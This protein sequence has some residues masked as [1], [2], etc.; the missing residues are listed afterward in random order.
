M[1]NQLPYSV[2]V[3]YTKVTGSRPP[4]GDQAKLSELST[5]VTLRIKK[6]N[7]HLEEYKDAP[8]CLMDELK[9]HK[10]N[11][12]AASL[13]LSNM[14]QGLED[15]HEQ[16]RSSLKRTVLDSSRR[17]A[18]HLEY[19]GDGKCQNGRCVL[20]DHLYRELGS[21]GVAPTPVNTGSGNQPGWT[22]P[23]LK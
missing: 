23:M 9:S 21:V 19:N 7:T 12:V 2:N 6:V 5:A 18:K 1:A 15:Y 8:S 3:V 22:F 13:H 17:S 11:L 16:A 14:T 10:A 4:Q 20:R